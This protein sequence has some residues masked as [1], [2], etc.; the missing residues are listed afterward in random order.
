MEVHQRIE[1]ARQLVP[2]E[3]HSLQ[4]QQV[5]QRAEP[6]LNQVRMAEAGSVGVITVVRVRALAP[7]LFVRWTMN[8]AGGDGYLKIV[9]KDIEH[10]EL[11]LYVARVGALCYQMVVWG[12]L[13]IADGGINAIRVNAGYQLSKR[14]QRPDQAVVAKQKNLER[15][16]P[17]E[18]R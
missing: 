7:F 18:V 14:V 9:A 4:L 16:E 2:V 15:H 10:P 1:G 17:I 3:H 13:K 12:G 11:G 6:S 8:V 5:L